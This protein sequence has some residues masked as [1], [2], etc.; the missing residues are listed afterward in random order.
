MCQTGNLPMTE[1]CLWSDVN[2]EYFDQ[3]SI[4]A[5]LSLTFDYPRL[6]SGLVER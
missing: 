5:K 1:N 4:D 6:S 3:L 2:L